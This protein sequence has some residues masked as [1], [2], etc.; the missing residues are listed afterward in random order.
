MREQRGNDVV[1]L[2]HTNE[3][4]QNERGCM[5]DLLFRF[6]AVRLSHNEV[7]ASKNHLFPSF[8]R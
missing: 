4:V 7:P 5:E 3:A 2:R 1:R 6:S 8:P